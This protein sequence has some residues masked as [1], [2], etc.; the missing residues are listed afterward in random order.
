MNFT[1]SA[2]DDVS[3]VVPAIKPARLRA[4]L[5][6]LGMT[7]VNVTATDGAGNVGDA[8]FT[9]TVRD[10]TAPVLTVPANMT[11]EAAGA[12]G[13]IGEFHDLCASDEISGVVPTI[14]LAGFGLSVPAR[15]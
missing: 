12:S 10:T 11:V 1:T 7:T 6:P 9:V 3:G 8:S 14:N 2:L 15:G 13:A 5:F 4:A